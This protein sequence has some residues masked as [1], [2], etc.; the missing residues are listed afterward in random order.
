MPPKGAQQP[1]KED[2]AKSLTDEI[3][4]E[5]VVDIAIEEHKLAQLRRSRSRATRTPHEGAGTHNGLLAPANGT[6]G[7][8]AVVSPNKKDKDE[9]L[10]ECM[11]SFA[12]TPGAP[13]TEYQPVR[14]RC[15]PSAHSPAQIAVPRYASHL[16]G[17]MGLSGARRGGER[18]SAA[19]SKPGSR[20]GSVAGSDTESS[21]AYGIKRSATASPGPGAGPKPKKAKPSAITAPGLAQYQ[22]PHTGSHPLSKTL[23]LPSS[24]LTPTASSPAPNSAGGRVVPP[25]PPPI[26]SAAPSPSSTAMHARQSSLPGQP[27]SATTANRPIH[28]LAQSASS[29]ASTRPALAAEASDSNNLAHNSDRPDSDSEND[30]D[31]DTKPPPLPPAPAQGLGRGQG[32]QGQKAPRAG[33]GGGGGGV[34][35]GAPQKRPGGGGPGV[36]AGAGGVGGGTSQKMP[37]GATSNGRP[38]RAA[39]DSGSDSDDDASDASSD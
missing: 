9:G 3:L 13:F 35:A 27:H 25:P 22:S 8:A 12:S 28:P 21:K 39:V 23:S 7:S 6:S 31:L 36:G 5:L 1:S 32:K 38:G 29:S 17:C 15:L 2:L 10:F 4:H 37:R 33:G 14:L 19:N 26:S 11:P 30:S 18:R 24:P 16:S 34:Q 20:P